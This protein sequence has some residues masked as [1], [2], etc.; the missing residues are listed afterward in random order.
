MKPLTRI[1]VPTIVAGGIALAGAM[2]AAATPAGPAIPHLVPHHDGRSAGPR[3]ADLACRVFVEQD[4][5]LFPLNKNGITK[6]PNEIKGATVGCS[7]P[8]GEFARG[9][10]HHHPVL[11]SSSYTS[12]G[13]PSVN[14]VTE[15]NHDCT[16]I[17]QNAMLEFTWNTG[18]RSIGRL[19][20]DAAGNVTSKIL[21][22]VMT[23][24]SF[25]FTG[26]AVDHIDSY[27]TYLGSCSASRTSG[28]ED[29]FIF[30]SWLPGATGSNGHEIGLTFT[31]K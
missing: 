19:T 16:S 5:F 12:V 17:A 25:T 15:L 7:S 10:R 22:G 2:P 13:G 27:V 3:S 14:N 30:N 8:N 24:D 21:A 11:L 4:D 6:S 18:D 9:N 20:I 28:E 1:L 23:G 29:G 31:H 26:P